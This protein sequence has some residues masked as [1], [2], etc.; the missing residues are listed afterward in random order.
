MPNS[1]KTNKKLHISSIYLVYNKYKTISIGLNK[2]V[3]KGEKKKKFENELFFKWKAGS[4][5]YSQ[6]VTKLVF[7]A[8]E[9]F[10]SVFG[11]GTGVS[12]LLLPPAMVECF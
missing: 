5:L 6:F 1:A 4:Y 8:L 7:L 12:P 2:I 10:T 11:M 9:V 3:K